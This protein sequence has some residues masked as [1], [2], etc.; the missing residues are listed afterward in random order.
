MKVKTSE[1]AGAALAWAVALAE[2]HK[3][4]L[5]RILRGNVA[6]PDEED[7]MWCDYLDYSEDW[8]LAGPIITRAKISIHF[9]VDTRDINGLYIHAHTMQNMDHGYWRGDHEKPLTAAMRCYCYAKLGEF[10]DIPEELCQQE[11]R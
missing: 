6:L 8:E 7:P 1:L 9:C 4:P 3:P 10:V 11:S 2:G 5:L